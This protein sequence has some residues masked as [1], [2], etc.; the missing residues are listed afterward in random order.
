[1]P[2][3]LLGV[4]LKSIANPRKVLDLRRKSGGSFAALSWPVLT[5]LYRIRGKSSSNENSKQPDTQSLHSSQSPGSSALEDDT[6]EEGLMA[7]EDDSGRVTASSSDL[8]FL[9]GRITALEAR[10]GQGHVQATAS[11]EARFSALESRVATLS[12][13]YG[14]LLTFVNELDRSIENP[15]PDADQSDQSGTV[16]PSFENHTTDLS[17]KQPRNGSSQTI[18][19]SP[20]QPLSSSSHQVMTFNVSLGSGSEGSELKHTIFFTPGVQ[21]NA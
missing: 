2:I 6:M 16:Q 10:F 4:L 18:H 15:P 1:M 21:P 12:Q 5:S 8:A 3:V 9:D 14:Q 20:H 11:L 7:L 17:P 13:T 19:V